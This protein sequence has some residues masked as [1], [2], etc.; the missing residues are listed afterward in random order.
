MGFER[1]DGFVDQELN[2]GGHAQTHISDYTNGGGLLAIMLD[3]KLT[4]F[5]VV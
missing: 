5:D 1:L 3:D 4:N 2:F